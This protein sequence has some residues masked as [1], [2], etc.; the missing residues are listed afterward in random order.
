MSNRSPFPNAGQQESPTTQACSN[1]VA[2]VMTAQNADI[3]FGSGHFW[4]RDVHRNLQHSIAAVLTCVLM[5]AA[6]SHSL[7]HQPLSPNNAWADWLCIVWRSR[8]QRCSFQSLSGTS[9]RQPSVNS[10]K[11]CSAMHQRCARTQRK[12]AEDKEERPDLS[13]HLMEV[14]IKLVTQHCSM[15]LVY[16]E[17][18][19]EE[20][21]EGEEQTTETVGDE[22][23]AG[24]RSPR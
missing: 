2:N 23:E 16:A 22:Q 11:G 5:F 21:G 14:P 6:V 15:E 19:E 10:K 7:E 4:P 24:R 17:L 13:L 18:Q 12:M 20:E 9:R 3:R 1:Q 8:L